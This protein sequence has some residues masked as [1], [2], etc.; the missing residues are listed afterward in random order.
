MSRLIFAGSMFVAIGVATAAYGDSTPR[1][2]AQSP[3]Y[4]TDAGAP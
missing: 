1:G 4:F 2:G 3:G